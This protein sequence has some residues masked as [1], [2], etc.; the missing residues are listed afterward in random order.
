MISRMT[1]S[2]RLAAA[3]LAAFWST[4]IASPAWADPPGSSYRLVFA[5]EFNGTTLDSSKWSAASPGWTMPNSASTA[6]ASDVSVANGVLTLSANRPSSTGSFSSGSISSYNKYS[7]TGG[8]VEARIQ[9]PSTPGSWPAFW[10]L[11]TGWPPEADIME[12]PLTTD[13]GT[14]GLP[15]NK[16]NTNYHY[17]NSSG[18]AAAG[19]GVVTTSGNLAG[20]WH[21]FGMQWTTNTSVAFYLDGTKVSSYASSSVSQMAYMY[22]I[23]DYAVGGWPGMPSLAQW[24]VGHVDQTLV[25]WVR[26]WQTNPNS[27]APTSWNVNGNG[28]FGAAGN[29]TAGVPQYGNQVATFGRVGTAPTATISLNAWQLFGGITFDGGSSGTTAYTLGAATNQ[30]QLATTNSSGVSVQATAASTVSQTINAGIELWSNT[31][32]SNNMTGS[33]LL[34]LN[35]NLSGAGSFTVSGPGTVVVAGS[36]SYSGGTV[37]GSA[38]RLPC[39]T[40]HPIRPWAPAA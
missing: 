36:N 21:T 6:T 1:R 38:R 29:W 28:A 19:A 39:S 24:P 35:G 15:N 3:F 5:D 11:Y 34:N 17:T 23:L 31:T 22:M 2:E 32:C 13:G 8:Y 7:F 10:G 26:V 33:Q 9:L 37:I 12:Y 20:T 4:G 16:Y 40:L 27:D 25:D 18:N 30:I 14:S